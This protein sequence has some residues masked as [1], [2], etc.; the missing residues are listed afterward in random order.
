MTR[1][2]ARAGGRWNNPGAAVVGTDMSAT[3][4]PVVTHVPERSRYELALD[5]RPVGAAL[6]VDDGARRIFHHT[7]IDDAY[8]GRGL[9]GTLVRAALEATRD[10]GWR[11]VPVCPYVQRWL[12]SHAEEAGV[13]GAVDP[14]TAAEVAAVERATR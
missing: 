12:G 9:A 4:Q 14:V 3:D 6:Y 10:D 8:G 11:I 1:R 5:G 13:A 2:P 7:E